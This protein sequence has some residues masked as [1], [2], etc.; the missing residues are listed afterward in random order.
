[1]GDCFFGQ[2]VDTTATVLEAE[3]RKIPPYAVLIPNACPVLTPFPAFK[4]EGEE[5]APLSR[6]L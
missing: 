4:G 5:C 6:A 1:M 3:M 2:S